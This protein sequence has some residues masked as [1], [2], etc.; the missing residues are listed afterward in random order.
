MNT[1]TYIGDGK[2]YHRALVIAAVLFASYAYF[3]EGGGWN[4]NSRFDVMRAV[5]EQHTLTIDAYHGNTGD[6]AFSRGHYYS[7]K[8][9]GVAF[10]AVPFVAAF[11]PVL[12]AF[13]VDPTSIRGL[14]ALAYVATVGAVALPAAL[15]AGCL[16]LIA[17]RLGATVNG[18]S[19]AAVSLGLA[20]PYWANSSMLFGHTLA[21]AC[22]TFSFAAAVALRE[23]GS[24]K[25]DL[26]LGL[27]A[28]L[29][30]GWATVTEYPAAPA[31]AVVA[32][33]VLVE[34]WPD[35]WRRRSRVAAGV[36][37]GAISCV[38]VLMAY[39]YYAFNS[40]FDP[41]YSHYPPGVFP[42]MQTGFHG[43]TYPH[44]G[45]ILRI[46][47]SRYSGLLLLAPVI[48]AAPF[49]LWLLWKKSSTR[50]CAVAGAII[51]TYYISF[52]ASFVDWKGGASYGPR[53]M[54][55]GLPMLCIGLAPAWD[56]ARRFW[57][58][59]LIGLAAVGTTLSLAAVSTNPI[60]WDHDYPYPMFQTMLPSFWAGRLSSCPTSVVLAD[61]IKVHEA[62]NL[63]ELAG[64]HGLLSLIPLIVF[65]CLGVLVFTSIGQPS[66]EDSVTQLQRSP[67]L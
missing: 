12:R 1:S 19:F 23:T 38:A 47:L 13:G 5:V 34:V 40:P 60:V 61:N 31:S 46:F 9:P 48:V 50:N 6:K 28:G 2:K 36:A 32:L 3:F 45:V 18:A 51:A 55:A 7:D 33:L 56:G 24:A 15:G 4:Q 54:L 59:L 8:A 64:L 27:V 44:L 52:N 67:L 39:Q 37:A 43:L 10:L 49:G 30:A 42:R 35:G 14:V 58:G 25:R 21:G 66:Q 20:T 63:G 16:F 17:L 29:A 57:R 65:W 26:L 53:Y 11:R 22:L 62:F 41:G